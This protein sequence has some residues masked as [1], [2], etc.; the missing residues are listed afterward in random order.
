L[1]THHTEA[2]N[3]AKVHSKALST[4]APVLLLLAL[5]TGPES[6]NNI[7]ALVKNKSNVH[8]RSSSTEVS[9]EERKGVAFAATP[10]GE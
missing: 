8:A 2:K 5:A 10:S 1:N 6:A 4:L 3:N 9:A 7:V